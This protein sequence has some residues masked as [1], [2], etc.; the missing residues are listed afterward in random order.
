MTDNI[1]VVGIDPGIVDTGIVS[2]AF[3]PEEQRIEREFIVLTQATPQRVEHELRYMKWA[4]DHIFI[5]AYRPRSHF[6]QDKNMMLL[7]QGIKQETGGKTLL[8][9]GIKSVVRRG[10]LELLNIWSFGVPTHHD[11]LRS[12]ARILVLGMLKNPELNLILADRVRDELNS[13]G[14]GMTTI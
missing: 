6:V 8:N 12:A 2:L 5:E 4:P 1:V 10:L 11:D 7:V 13:T 9:T 3:W 14:W